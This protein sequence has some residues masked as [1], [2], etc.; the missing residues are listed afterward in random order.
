[1]ITLDTLTVNQLDVNNIVLTWDF[2]T[3][4]ENFTDYTLEIY[5]SESPGSQGSLVGYDK[6]AD[7]IDPLIG[8]YTDNTLRGLRT[9]G[10]V[11]YYKLNII[12]TST[13]V[14]TSQ[15]SFASFFK[16][17]NLDLARK[18]IL[19]QKRI[20]LEKLSGRKF[21]VLRRRTWGDHCT[22]CWDT[23][24]FR[25]ADPYCPE[26]YG[27]GWTQGYFSPIPFYGMITPSPE[28]NQIMMFGEWKPSDTL[29][30]MLSYPILREKDVVADDSG[31]R[32][33]AVQIQK[34]EKLGF[35]LEQ[36]VQ[37][38]LIENDD[39]VY[40]LPVDYSIPAEKYR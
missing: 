28:R 17:S 31:N 11:W 36:K 32:W 13:Q 10:R 23:V 8:T 27:T 1:M 34:V 33:V 5:R 16:K 14:S 22:K 35:L 40:I 12:Q 6:I 20:V 39:V 18:E 3:T 9:A 15:P 25:A 24:L 2:L 19:R 37:L 29:L 21:F 4:S 30:E 38:A 7:T 26:C